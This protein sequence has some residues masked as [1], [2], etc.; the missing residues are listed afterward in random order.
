MTFKARRITA[1]IV[2][3]I[4]MIAFNCAAKS[5]K[6][7]KNTKIQFGARTI[8]LSNDIKFDLPFTIVGPYKAA[9]DRGFP[10][11]LGYLFQTYLT[12]KA[13]FSGPLLY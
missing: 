11:I 13:L 3:V 1:I 7:E 2:I 9:I 12:I 10:N 4:V 6:S 5:I 8:E